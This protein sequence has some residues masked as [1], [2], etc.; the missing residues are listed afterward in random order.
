[1]PCILT[2]LLYN[3]TKRKISKTGT[4]L[5]SKHTKWLNVQIHTN[6]FYRL[7]SRFTGQYFVN[8]VRLWEQTYLILPKE[9]STLEI[10]ACAYSHDSR[11]VSQVD[12]LLNNVKMKKKYVQQYKFTTKVKLWPKRGCIYLYQAL[13]QIKRYKNT[14]TN[15]SNRII[16]KYNSRTKKGKPEHFATE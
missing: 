11:Q 12:V 9:A 14:A 15:F 3:L 8:N 6:F 13:A 5:D 4:L 1:M 10:V 16:N 2:E 7:S